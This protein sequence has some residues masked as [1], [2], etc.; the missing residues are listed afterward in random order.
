ML[1]DEGEVE[2]DRAL[3]TLPP[4][5]L[6]DWLTGTGTGTG[7]GAGSLLVLVPRTWGQWL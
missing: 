3:V 6:T 5:V 7:T 4:Q 1:S 2:E